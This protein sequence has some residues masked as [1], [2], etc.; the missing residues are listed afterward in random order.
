MSLSKSVSRI[1]FST[2]FAA[3]L[4]GSAALCHAEALDAYIGVLGGG[5]AALNGSD[6][7][8]RAQGRL[9]FGYLSRYVSLDTRVG[10][11][12]SYTNFGGV[13]RFFGHIPF[14]SGSLTGISLGMGA[15]AMYS[16][17]S[18]T[19]PNGNRKFV[20][21]LINPFMRFVW[22]W[23]VWGLDVD[24]GYEGIPAR[25]YSDGQTPHSDTTFRSRVN[26]GIGFLFGV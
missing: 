7:G 12:D 26:L 18:S 19:D 16:T 23:G 5:I 25:F 10:F 17:G 20:E 11:G 21:P 2:I 1:C 13:L 24:L 3:G 15:G 8:V 6:K 9:D 14:Q 4:F 22:D